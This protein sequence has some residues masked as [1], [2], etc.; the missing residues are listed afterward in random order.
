MERESGALCGDSQE[1]LGAAESRLLSLSGGLAHL[2]PLRFC[3]LL[4]VAPRVFAS[5]VSSLPLAWGGMR[6]FL[7]VLIELKS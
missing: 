1:N 3:A 7:P 6:V 5:L 2:S 4:V